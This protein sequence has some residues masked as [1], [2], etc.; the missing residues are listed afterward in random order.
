MRITTRNAKP[1]D[2]I[3]WLQHRIHSSAVLHGFVEGLP[4][5]ICGKHERPS[6]PIEPQTTIRCARCRQVYYSH[7]AAAR[8]AGRRFWPKDW[9]KLHE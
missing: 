1:V 6:A 3:E 5:S 7:I 8:E 9:G 2:Q 4:K